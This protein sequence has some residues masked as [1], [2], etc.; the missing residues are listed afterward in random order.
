MVQQFEDS[1]KV[2]I[3]TFIM[4]QNILIMLKMYRPITVSGSDQAM[5]RT[6]QSQSQ[7]QIK[8]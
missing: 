7:D 6:D 5:R 1:K 4:L 8:Q 3:K 2:S